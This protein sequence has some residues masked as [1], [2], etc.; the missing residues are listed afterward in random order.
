L[1]KRKLEILAMRELELRSLARHALDGPPDNEDLLNPEPG[2]DAQL[3]LAELG[4]RWHRWYRFKM[5]MPNPAPTLRM[6][7][8]E[9]AA[10]SHGTGLDATGVLAA[11]HYVD[12]R[13]ASRRQWRGHIKRPLAAHL[14]AFGLAHVAS[15]VHLARLFGL[16]DRDA[17]QEETY[18]VQPEVDDMVPVSDPLRDWHISHA[19]EWVSETSALSQRCQPTAEPRAPDGRPAD[20]RPADCTEACSL[21]HAAKR[22]RLSSLS[23]SPLDQP[24]SNDRPVFTVTD[25]CLSSTGAASAVSSRAGLPTY[26]AGAAGSA[27]RPTYDPKYGPITYLTPEQITQCVG[28]LM[29]KYWPEPPIP[30]PAPTLAPAP[31]LGSPR[32]PMESVASAVVALMVGSGRSDN[33]DRR[34]PGMLTRAAHRRRDEE[35]KDQRAQER[36]QKRQRARDQRREKTDPYYRSYSVATGLPFEKKPFSE[37]ELL[38]VSSSTEQSEQASEQAATREER[39]VSIALALSIV[40]AEHGLPGLSVHDAYLTKDPVTL[41][42][43]LDQLIEVSVPQHLRDHARLTV[44]PFLRGSGPCAARQILKTPLRELC[45]MT[46]KPP[47]F[48]FIRRGARRDDVSTADVLRKFTD[49]MPQLTRD[50]CKAVLGH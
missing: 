28:N 30:P 32:N 33:S 15:Q 44:P 40:A 5:L 26:A 21:S 31:A 38:Y 20:G 41:H 48:N 19:R 45:G 25:V 8:D 2:T 39:F 18:E 37:L 6:T 24:W 36:A 50:I 47:H 42:I 17:E 7:A 23:N 49:S 27:G 10:R 16:E 34:A 3:A 9:V 29:A 4:R 13:R 1:A 46:T 22:P 35:E 12:M 11:I 14:E 43:T